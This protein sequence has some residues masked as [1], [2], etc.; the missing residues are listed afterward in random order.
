MRGL[1][2]EELLR[3]PVCFN[4]IELGRPVDVLID[5]GASRAVGLE[6][7]CGDDERRFLPLAVAVVDGDSIA[8]ESPLLFVGESGLSFYREEASTLRALRGA[9]IE[10]RGL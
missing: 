2:G 8:I 7:V 5:R 1:L 9:R 4:G 10:Q 6:V 3:L